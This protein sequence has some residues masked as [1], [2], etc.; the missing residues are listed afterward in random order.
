M[1]L[2]FPLLISLSS[3]LALAQIDKLGWSPDLVVE[4]GKGV[5]E[6]FPLNNHFKCF[7]MSK[8][9]YKS[10]DGVGLNGAVSSDMKISLVTNKK[11][12]D[13]IL[14][15]SGKVSAHAS[16]IKALEKVGLPAVTLSGGY[17]KKDS[18]DESS[19]AL[20]ISVE[21]DYGRYGLI[22]PDGTELELRENFKQMLEGKRYNEF[23]KNCGTHYVSQENRKGRVTAVI[24]ISNLTNDKKRQIAASLSL[25]KTL[26]QYQ[27]SPDN[28]TQVEPQ[29]DPSTG[30]QI[31]TGS[32]TNGGYVFKL[33]YQQVNKQPGI[34]LGVDNFLKSAKN[35]SGTI[36][37]TLSARGG[38]G[39]VAY[40]K[41]FE[42]EK[43]DITFKG[44]MDTVS[45]YLKSYKINQTVE[46][47]ATDESAE[48]LATAS[49]YKNV[50]PGAPAEYYLTSYDLYGLPKE[51]S[52]EMINNDLLEEVY[53]LYIAAIGSLQI[54]NTQLDMV[55]P[56]IENETFDKLSKTKIEYEKYLRVLW[57]LAG[58]I[59]D[60][61]LSNDPK[62]DALPKKPLLKLE[63]LLLS[64]NITKASLVCSSISKTSKGQTSPVACGTRASAWAAAGYPAWRSQFEVEGKVGAAQKLESMIL[65]EVDAVSGTV[66]KQLI[67]VN[68]GDNLP[69]A[70]LD[71]SGNFKFKF[72]ELD[73][74][75]GYNDYVKA[76]QNL[77]RFEIV[78]K[79][80]DGDERT[81][82]VKNFN[83]AGSNH[84]QLEDIL[85]AEKKRKGIESA[86]RPTI[87]TYRPGM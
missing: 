80:V 53:Y 64:I 69:Y 70:S 83:L 42:D 23:L 84:M 59:M 20:V 34:S 66:V 46:T 67:I 7:D 18:L 12:L 36:E 61:N 57:K 27:G 8:A 6:S 76:R 21:T 85:A 63:D 56:T 24:K 30:E 5:T 78:L 79:S 60:N 87:G 38:G 3:T 28:Q 4:L 10:I 15:I 25:G 26:N 65:R 22:N 32:G 39:M 50:L 55:D 43:G 74:I 51:K 81:F 68:P 40:T 2:M 16:F 62:I 73:Q 11:E 82:T 52:R 72:K 37:V 19:I 35:S 9:V 54:V 47:D 33:P 17:G 71:M 58:D 44:L 48:P 45:Q 77:F 29:Y 41:I 31:P 1:K 86:G 14:G 75:K 13:N 49:N